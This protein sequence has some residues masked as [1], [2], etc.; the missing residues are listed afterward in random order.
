MSAINSISADKLGR[1]IGTPACPILIDVRTDDNFA[2]DPK[3]IPSAIRRNHHEV[4]EWAPLYAGKSVIAICARGRK[5]SEGVAAWLRVAGSSA[6]ILDGG[7]E[8]W[9]AAKLP[10]VP[11]EKIPPRDAQGRTVWVTRAR[12]KID[13]IACP[14]LI[15]R[16]VDPTAIFLFVTSSEVAPVAE[17]FKAVPFD[18]EGVHWGHRGELCTFDIMIEEFG[19]TMEPLDRL[20]AIVRGADT[21]RLDLAPQAPGLMAAALGLSRMYSDDLAQLDAGMLLFDAF[22]RWCRDATDETHNWPSH[23]AKKVKA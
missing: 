20:A 22:Y 6:N 14:W 2:A 13:R 16:F 18:I 15:R 21:A 5:T 9:T 8:A 11:A 4:T 7:M 19:L 23:T 10:L 3:L 1:L 12:P 17:Q